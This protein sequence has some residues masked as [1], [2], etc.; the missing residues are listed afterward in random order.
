LPAN[1]PARG[2]SL[3]SLPLVGRDE[4]VARLKHAL[5]DAERGAPATIF[6]AGEG[7]VGKTRLAESLVEEAG[8]RGWK[9]AVGRAYPVETGVPYALFSDALL[10]TL[11]AMDAA[12]LAVMS[13]GGESEL[14][15]LFPALELRADPRAARGDPSDLKARLL[16]T[17]SQFL[18]RLA[19]KRPL[20]LVLENLQWADASS[21]ELLHFTARQLAGQRVV[22]LCSY[23]DAQRE[24]NAALSNTERS[25]VGLGAS[26]V[27]RVAPLS[28]EEND[29]LLARVFS[30]E[31]ATVRDFAALLYERTR[32]N[33]FFVEEM[34]KSLVDS[35][36][37]RYEQ[38]RWTGWEVATL[39]LPR[40]VRD[41]IVAR[42][43]RLSASARTVVDVAAVLG[44]RA[45]YGALATVTALPEPELVEAI[46]ELRR[47][48]ILTDADGPESVYYDFTH[49]SLQATLYG[50][51]GKARTRLLHGRIATALEHLYG[52][53]AD[54]HADEL[55]FHFA[56]ATSPELA[57]KAARYLATAGRAALAR[58]A[59]REAATYLGAALDLI[60]R[61]PTAGEPNAAA[62]D[63]S[64]L[65]EDLA[66]AKQRNGEYGAARVL[67]E[68]ALRDARAANDDA[69]VS[70]LERRLGVASFWAGDNEQASVHYAAGLDAAR[71]AGDERLAARI[72]IAQAVSFMELGRPD[73]ARRELQ[74][75]LAIAERLKHAGMLPR[76][77]RALMQLDMFV[78]RAAE[79]REHGE[80]AIA[81]AS[82]ANEPAVAW[83]AHWAIAVLAGLT[84][85]AGELAN[86]V[87][88]AQRIAEELRS[89]VLAVWTSEVSIEYASG[90]GDWQSG[91]ALAERTIPTARALG[92]KTLLPRLLVWTGLMHLGRGE[93]ETAKALF[94]E[95]WT[96]SGAAEAERGSVDVHSVVPAHTGMAAYA[97][98]TGDRQRAIA[99]GEAGVRLADQSGYVTWAVHRLV[100]IIIEASLWLQD[101]ERAAQYGERLR[102]DSARIGHKLGMAWATASDA[103]VARLR[104]QDL[105]RAIELLRSA[106]DEL[107]AVPFVYDAARVRRN[108]A[109]L[110]AATGDREAAT[111]ELKR[112]HDVFA[113]IGAETELS[114]ARD[115]LR[116]LGARPPARVI[117]EGAG[118][119]TGRE[120]EIARLVAARKSNKE[121]GAALGISS[122]TVSTHLSN[123][124]AKLGVTSR[125]E[126]TD[127]V[128]EDA[129]LRDA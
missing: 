100:P 72:R 47:H 80:R 75:A 95:S 30:V 118:A 60:D 66:R 99:L 91:L 115:Q 11:R 18:G 38:G 74:E 114:G 117:A 103:L 127:R 36:Q 20:L 55:A 67:W 48:R 102:R 96:L 39:D 83:S 121:I 94:E 82:T 79:A 6:L 62:A 28:R 76:V 14:A 7:G 119:L 109:Q 32:G 98:A 33:P 57:P 120:R 16:W 124:F 86:H 90:I 122:R 43:E 9:T 26:T 46:D 108:L 5:E 128:R 22:I 23:N 56:R 49:P 112:A 24:S 51:L 17:F 25:L 2:R 78:G 59:S 105:P 19:S 13:R 111:R 97:L 92:A 4:Q 41:A 81:F 126:L 31:P 54:Q 107:D 10:P 27:L 123:V 1:A 58:Y 52:A 61:G 21:L 53:S 104:D 113:R 65:V 12:T 15:R 50:E 93:L 116:D 69:R 70:S 34:L 42:L 64:S 45:S 77:H 29:E 3:G 106:A 84:G 37:L 71:R 110:L 40:T 44:T 8:R 85:N 73:E 88:E 68:R 129:A 101:F 35:G 125:G 63:V 87:R 89:P